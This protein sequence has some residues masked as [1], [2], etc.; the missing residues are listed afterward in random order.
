MQANEYTLSLRRLAVSASFIVFCSSS[1]VIADSG[2]VRGGLAKDRISQTSHTIAEII[3]D[4]TLPDIAINYTNPLPSKEGAPWASRSFRWESKSGNVNKQVVVKTPVKEIAPLVVEQATVQEDERIFASPENDINYADIPS[5]KS[6]ELVKS[7]LPKLKEETLSVTNTLPASTASYD[8]VKKPYP[9]SPGETVAGLPWFVADNTRRT[10]EKI[11]QEKKN[12]ALI[13]PVPDALLTNNTFLLHPAINAQFSA[14]G[15]LPWQISQSTGK[16]E[17]PV[18]TKQIIIEQAAEV[19]AVKA[20]ADAKPATLQPLPSYNVYSNEKT[21]DEQPALKELNGINLP[22]D[23]TPKH[24]DTNNEAISRQSKDILAKLPPERPA[25][26]QKLQPIE[27]EH[28]APNALET[29]EV[30]AHTGIGVKMSVKK[31]KVDI[32]RLLDNAY[33]ELMNG[34]QERAIELYNYV[35]QVQPNNKLAIFGLA[36]TY[37]RAGQLAQARALYGKLLAIDPANVEGLNNFLVLLSDEDAREA[38]AELQKLQKTHPNFS[39]IPA[40]LSVIYAKMEQ[41]DLAIESMKKAIEI[42]PE[43]LKYRYNLAIILDKAGDW[44]DAEIFYRQILTAID[45][46][47]RISVNAKEIQERLTFIVSNKK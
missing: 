9:E 4:I 26:M 32:F 14:D 41:Y 20:V 1:G 38:I 3:P 46:G 44:Q 15:T 5:E 33:E 2:L 11:L 34:N 45:R 27:M 37:H 23:T 40:Q 18:Q 31:P 28:T 6:N 10:A 19:V 8:A 24:P 35:L 36:T 21:L 16:K 13:E 29:D 43:N 12:T 30:K 39:P 7:T 47:E 17:E 25:K 22:K 42:S